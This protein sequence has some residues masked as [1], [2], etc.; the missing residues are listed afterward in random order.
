MT[1]RLTRLFAC[2]ALSLAL[3][4]PVQARDRHVLWTV[5][6]QHNTVDQLGSIHVLRASD[7]GL[8]E[9]ADEAYADAEALAAAPAERA[10]EQ[11]DEIDRL[12]TG[13]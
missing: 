10:P 8:P 11:P 6:G 9:A 1:A 3:A 7:G 5:A 13:G 12:F 4:V 2:G